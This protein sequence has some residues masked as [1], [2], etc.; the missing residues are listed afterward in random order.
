MPLPTTSSPFHRGEREIQE[1]LGVREQ[2]EEV[3]KRFIRGFMP[4]EHRAFYARLPF[5][6]I[7]SVD[8]RAPLGVGSGGAPW[9]RS[10]HHPQQAEG[11]RHPKP[12]ARKGGGKYLQ[13]FP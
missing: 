10:F 13:M 11:R 5:L 7:G 8:N 2:I 1:R 12:P 9:L 6:L 4:G 3:G